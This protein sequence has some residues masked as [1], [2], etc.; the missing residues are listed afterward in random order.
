VHFTEALDLVQKRKVYLHRGQAYVQ[1]EDMISLLTSV[2]RQHLKQTLA[3]SFILHVLFC[4]L[5]N[6]NI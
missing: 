2:Y 3:V 1:Y 5:H 4:Y 6:F